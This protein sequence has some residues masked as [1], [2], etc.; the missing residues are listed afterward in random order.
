MLTPQLALDICANYPTVLADMLTLSKTGIQTIHHIVH[1]GTGTCLPASALAKLVPSQTSAKH[2]KAINRITILL[3]TL[4]SSN[5]NTTQY[6]EAI[7][8]VTTSDLS[9]ALRQVSHHVRTNIMSRTLASYPIQ[10]S[11]CKHDSHRCAQPVIVLDL[12]R[13]SHPTSGMHH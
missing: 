4:G 6:V 7:K 5:I 9:P 11:L 8:N 2:R 10:T 12:R 3:H 13:R 1:G